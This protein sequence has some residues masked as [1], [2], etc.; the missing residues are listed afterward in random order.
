[1]PLGSVFAASFR[2]LRGLTSS[3]DIAAIYSP[4]LEM[5]E[6][7]LALCATNKSLIQFIGTSMKPQKIAVPLELAG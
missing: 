2:A 4:L 6:R 3:I 5:A 7:R 1:M